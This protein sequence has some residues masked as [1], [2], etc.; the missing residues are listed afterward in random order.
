MV[1]IVDVLKKVWQKYIA[2]EVVECSHCKTVYTVE[3]IKEIG[4]KVPKGYMYICP[5]CKKIDL[6]YEEPDPKG[7]I[8]CQKVKHYSKFT[9]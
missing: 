5:V 4:V 6:Y 3:R 2:A 7:G 8:I 9:R 1:K